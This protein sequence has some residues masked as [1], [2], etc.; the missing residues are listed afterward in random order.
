MTSPKARPGSQTRVV[1]IIFGLAHALLEE[2]SESADTEQ[3]RKRS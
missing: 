3:P 1:A 2:I